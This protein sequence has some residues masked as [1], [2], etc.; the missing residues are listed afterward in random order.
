MPAHPP[1]LPG[2]TRPLHLAVA[3]D[4]PGTYAAEPYVE[5]AR[6]AE[7]GCLDFVTLGDAP[8]PPGGGGGGFDA[9]AVLA[10]VAPATARIGLVPT[11]TTHRT[12]PFHLSSALATLDRVS[13]GRAGWTVEAAAARRE[14]EAAAAWREAGAVAEAVARLWDS[15]EDDAGIRDVATGRFADRGKLHRVDVEG[16][17][18]GVRGP[19]VVPRPPQGR[20]VIAVDATARR[21][22]ETAA[23]HA[24]IAYVRTGAVHDPRAVRALRAA[25]ADLR[26]RALAHGRDPAS[27]AGRLVLLASVPVALYTAADAVALADL[28]AGWYAD[29][30][31]DGFHFRPAAP[32]RDLALLVD[33]TVP[34]LQHRGLL[35]NFYPG[36]T[37]REHL[38]L[39]RPA[40]RCASAEE[41]A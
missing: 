9:L 18:S 25:R 16:P 2:P 5:A 40:N 17:G 26:R 32:D 15:R 8:G 22:R 34:V 38:C 39:V 31:A 10:R 36:G 12:E 21:P 41:T 14:A 13:R 1:P 37:L 23:R 28:V 24:D 3:L 27:R 30:V 6:L 33:G 4:R 7:R 35:R 19:A 29:G 20:P 11:V